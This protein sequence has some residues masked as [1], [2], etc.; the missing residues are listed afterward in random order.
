MFNK[1]VLTFCYV[2][3]TSEHQ[4]NKHDWD[5]GLSSMYLKII[6]WQS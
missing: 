4:G 5:M 3:G 6:G 2:Q 1:C